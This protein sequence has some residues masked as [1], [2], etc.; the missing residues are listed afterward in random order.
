MK[1]NDATE[2]AS[3]LLSGGIRDNHE[4]QQRRKVS[5]FTLVELMVTLM[6]VAI[7]LAVA[8]PHFG[9]FIARSRVRSAT[10]DLVTALA[11]ARS[12]AILQRKTVSV[13]AA[14]NDTGDDFFTHGW[15][16]VAAEN[17]A[18]ASSATSVQDYAPNQEVGLSMVAGSD[19]EFAFT[20]N[21]DL[22]NGKTLFLEASPKARRCVDVNLLG[23]VK[24]T[25]PRKDGGPPCPGTNPNHMSCG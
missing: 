2:I 15:R 13:C 22:A 17:C 7:L 19:W 20:Q 16:I 21:G 24:V 1:Q 4:G 3:F 12:T 9:E 11:T 14:T 23:Y 6:V 10:N 18:S 25:C 5:G 8:L